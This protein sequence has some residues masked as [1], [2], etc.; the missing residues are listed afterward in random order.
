MQIKGP[1]N[2]QKNKVVRIVENR[3]VKSGFWKENIKMNFRRMSMR[4]EI[5]V[6]VLRASEVLVS[7]PME[8]THL[9][10]P[11]N[12][13]NSRPKDPLVDVSLA[14]QGILH[15]IDKGSVTIPVRIPC[16]WKVSTLWEVFLQMVVVIEY[17]FIFF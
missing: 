17:G 16:W 7:I 4:L 6:E 15:G 11:P 9:L 8:M 13:K 1:L 2:S 12:D 14:M 3:Q 5:S 10:Q